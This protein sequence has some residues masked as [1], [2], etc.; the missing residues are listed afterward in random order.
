MSHKPNQYVALTAWCGE[1]PTGDNTRGTSSSSDLK[2]FLIPRSLR[3]HCTEAPPRHLCPIVVLLELQTPRSVPRFP[4]QSFHLSF[5][6][7]SGGTK[8]SGGRIVSKIARLLK[9]CP[10]VGIHTQSKAQVKASGGD[11]E[12]N[13]HF[14]AFLP[15]F[16]LCSAVW[17]ECC[18]ILHLALLGSCQAP[19]LHGETQQQWGRS[20]TM[21]WDAAMRQCQVLL[22][23]APHVVPTPS[24]FCSALPL[25]SFICPS[26]LFFGAV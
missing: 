1:V 24:A 3:C 17:E 8:T 12:S 26:I 14:L 23:D 5:W 6:A 2:C 10:Q 16:L 9:N 22:P 25:S 11:S 19:A 20:G 13:F 21:P 18:S 7:E 4:A 15:H